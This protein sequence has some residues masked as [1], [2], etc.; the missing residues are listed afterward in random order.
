MSIGG[1][2]RIRSC[3]RKSRTT[4]EPIVSRP[5]KLRDWLLTLRPP[6]LPWYT[7]DRAGSERR[8]A[9]RPTRQL[10]QQQAANIVGRLMQGPESEHAFREL[11]GDLL[12]FHR[13]E[14]KARLVV[15]VYER[16]VHSRGTAWTMA[17]ASAASS[18]T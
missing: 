8:A 2:S 6:E 5:S 10:P 14:A 1:R 12:A 17:N 11:V 4:T 13:R 16:R 18:G 7:G 15:S 9:L 3:L